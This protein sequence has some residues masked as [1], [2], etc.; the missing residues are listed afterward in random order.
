MLFA[1]RSTIFIE[2]RRLPAT[3]ETFFAGLVLL[4]TASCA[5][6]VVAPSF[7][8]IKALLRSIEW[9]ARSGLHKNALAFSIHE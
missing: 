2:Q 8:R 1:S 3:Q 9:I 6:K 5:E 7:E 4:L